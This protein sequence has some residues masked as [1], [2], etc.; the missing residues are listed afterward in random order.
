MAQ[1]NHNCK[2]CGRGYRACVTCLNEMNYAP[3]RAIACTQGHFQAYM[4]LWEYDGGTLTKADAKEM[5][6]KLDIEGWE[7]YPEVNRA[8]IAKILEA[9]EPLPKMDEPVAVEEVVPVEIAV[10]KPTAVTPAPAH[11]PKPKEYQHQYP[12]HRR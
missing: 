10:V 12:K 11:A 5:L 7:N 8:L 2:V 6:S 9:D 1:H 4:V 3:W